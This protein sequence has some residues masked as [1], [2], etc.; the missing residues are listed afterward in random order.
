M[1]HDKV[2]ENIFRAKKLRRKKLAQLPFKKKIEILI[3]LQK[4]AKGV[5]RAGQKSERMIWMI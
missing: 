5:H 1:N 4:M 3:E 2:A